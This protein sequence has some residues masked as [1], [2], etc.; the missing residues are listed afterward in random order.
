MWTRNV[1]ICYTI[2]LL[3]NTNI[4]HT[5][6]EAKETLLS[7]SNN[8][9][10]YKTSTHIKIENAMF[11]KV[12]EEQEKLHYA[13]ED[14]K[15]L[16]TD[17]I[18][19]NEPFYNQQKIKENNNNKKKTKTTQMNPSSLSEDDKNNNNKNNKMDRSSSTSSMNWDWLNTA[20]QQ[21]NDMIS[22]FLQASSQ[23]NTNVKT[24]PPKHSDVNV[25]DDAIENSNM[26]KDDDEDDGMSEE[27]NNMKKEQNGKEPGEIKSKFED[28]LDGLLGGNVDNEEDDAN[29]GKDHEKQ[30]DKILNPKTKKTEGGIDDK[31]KKK[32]IVP[33]QKYYCHHYDSC[34]VRTLRGPSTV[35]SLQNGHMCICNG[36]AENGHV[37]KCFEG[38]CYDRKAGSKRRDD[39]DLDSHG[40]CEY[41]AGN[42]VAISQCELKK[43]AKHDP[44]TYFYIDNGLSANMKQKAPG[45]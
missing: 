31:K 1:V 36:A 43:E 19:H 33:G 5:T 37:G 13:K 10:W 41:T 24:K 17:Y 34:G 23:T 11:G 26:K 44:N 20:K 9:P 7:S 2:L 38:I 14:E 42:V 45:K 40:L 25:H 8:K 22:L 16:E 4:I 35:D 18:K 15:K 28:S 32:K 27:D 29:S 12:S 3:F 30:V 21:G 39:A 6:C